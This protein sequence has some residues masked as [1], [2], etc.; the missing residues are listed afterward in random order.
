MS[1]EEIAKLEVGHTDV[2]RGV[3]ACLVLL[4][5]ALIV[6][7][8]IRDQLREA[9]PVFFRAAHI[10]PAAGELGEA[11]REAGVLGGVKAVN[12]RMLR[13]IHQFEDAI[14]DESPLSNALIPP[15]QSVLMA[16]LGASNENAYR[17]RDG[18]LFFRPGVDYLTGPGFLEPR[19]LRTRARMGDE[20]NPPP[21]PDPV[22]AIVAFRDQLSRFGVELL[23][24][25]AP[26][27]PM[28]Y[29][30]KLTR[31]YGDGHR[32]L[33]NPSYGPFLARLRECGVRCCD[34]SAALML[35][36]ERGEGDLFLATDT[37]W[38]PKGLAVAAQTLANS[39]RNEKVLP[40]R[41]ATAYTRMAKEVEN[42]G[43]IARMLKLPEDQQFYAPECVEVAEIRHPDGQL[44]TP[45]EDADVLLLGDSFANIY[46]FDGMGW[47]EHAGLA[48]QLSAELERP[49]DAICI[50]DS[51]AF[52]TRRELSRELA[53]GRN[54]LA[55]KKLV[56]WEFAMRELAVGDWKT[57]I[58][59]TLGAAVAE[60]AQ[61]L[62]V[63]GRIAALTRPPKPGDVPY[64]DCLVALHLV[65]LESAEAESVSG[66]A[67]AFV[68]GMRDHRWTAA[69]HYRVGDTMAF[70]LTPWDE[71]EPELGGYNRVELDDDALLRLD[72]YWAAV[73]DIEPERPSEP[74]VSLQPEKAEPAQAPNQVTDPFL[75][76]LAEYASGLEAKGANVLRGRDGWLFFGPELRSLSVGPFW[77]EAAPAVSRA[78]NAEEADPL[79]AILDFHRQLSAAGIELLLVPVPAKAAV[80]PDGLPDGDPFAETGPRRLDAYQQA[81]F[82][83]LAEQDIE[84]L[85]IEPVFLD[86]RAD[87][88]GPV[89]CRHD[90]H[91]SGRGCAV[92]AEAI[93]ARIG[94]PAWREEGPK[95]AFAAETR[96]VS[97]T[98]DLARFLGEDPPPLE[99]LPLTFVSEAG[100]ESKPVE[101]WRESPILLLGDSHCLVFS[102]GGDMH[103]RSAGLPEHLALRLGF[104]T[105]VV[106]VR[107][108][109]ATPARINL[110]RRRDN[111]EGKHLVVWCFSIREFTE[112][113]GGWRLLPVIQ[114]PKP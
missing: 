43:D 93:A 64:K 81:F 34:V 44:W 103:A 101:S 46:A 62:R 57:D 38:T 58:E 40:E 39:I 72:T 16:R 80:Y 25:P 22:E 114:E 11:A 86:H 99:T 6:A 69:A 65:D 66:E 105:D 113:P 84:V 19:T 35:A 79:A 47:G 109:G 106:A 33:Q 56:V 107:G 102:A 15:M 45:V 24:M 3:A 55:G 100:T 61:H 29:A 21:Q 23:L 91:W 95:R 88:E 70:E 30:E 110:L 4:F 74:D 92:A 7:V 10:L 13:D 94:D 76:Q 42:L 96:D 50:N 17:G 78:R 31:R 37:H 68:W 51:G 54:R 27:K 90:S 20:W 49:V 75:V 12:A 36:K 59:L 14:E 32:V 41:A 82:G 112:A 8:P 73:P 67:V 28:I 83:V 85:D 89:F 5:L 111:L 26:V 2:T 77:G 18:W 104:A 98:G 53:R 87:A 71:V 60:G 1:R 52:A 108:S 97:I 63:Q 48:A 9:T